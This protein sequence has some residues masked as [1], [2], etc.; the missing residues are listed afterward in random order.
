MSYGNRAGEIRLEVLA[1]IERYVDQFKL[2]AEASGA[3]VHEAAD[4]RSAQDIVVGLLN[5]GNV[6]RVVKSKSMIF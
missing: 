6:R 5:R 4:A 2:N 3:T 1:D